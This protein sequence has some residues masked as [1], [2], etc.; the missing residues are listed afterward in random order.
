VKQ[1]S[2]LL[3]QGLF[4]AVVLYFLP[5]RYLGVAAS[6]LA[7]ELVPLTVQLLRRAQRA[8][9]GPLSAVR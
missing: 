2:G 5:F 9:G 8:P 4:V 7:V 3:G 6:V 1:L